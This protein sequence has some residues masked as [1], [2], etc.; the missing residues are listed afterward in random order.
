MRDTWHIG[1]MVLV[2]LFCSKSAAQNLIK[3]TRGQETEHTLLINEVN[4]DSP[5]VDSAEFVGLYHT[6]GQTAHLDG[7]CLVL[8]NGNRNRAYEVLNFQG[9]VTNSQGEVLPSAPSGEFEFIELQGPHST[10]L[11]D[12]VLVL[13][14]GQNK[15]I[16]FT[17]AIY[18]Q[19]SLDGLLL[20][21]PAHSKA[22]GQE[23]AT[24][25]VRHQPGDVSMSQ[26]NCCSV[27]WDSTS[28]I[29]SRPTPGMFNDCP[30]KHFSQALFFCFHVSESKAACQDLGFVFT[31][32]LTARSEEQLSSILLAFS[33][34]LETPRVVNFDGRNITAERS[35]LRDMN[36]LNLPSGVQLE[37]PEGTPGP[38]VQLAKLLINEVNADN[39]GGGEDAEYIELFCV[40]QTCF[41]LQGHWLVLY[42]NSS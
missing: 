14:D 39:P 23:K 17:M 19:T 10:V 40:G 22:P 2:Y 21:S 4:A 1:F 8:Y 33:T 38:S 35:C 5:G 16:Y 34:F 28:F 36:V 26:C 12:I 29:F 3:P 6:S 7:Y 20:I 27:T 15:D 11:R 41:D 9:K 37:I 31:T 32:L 25:L 42:K 24:R 13:V 18:G 30:N